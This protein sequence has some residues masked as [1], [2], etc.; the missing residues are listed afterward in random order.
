MDEQI[1]WCYPYQ[2]RCVKWTSSHK[3]ILCTLEAVS[4]WVGEEN[5]FQYSP[6]GSKCKYKYE[7]WRNT[8]ST[9]ISRGQISMQQALISV[10]CVL[11]PG[12]S[13]PL[14][15]MVGCQNTFAATP[16]PL[17]FYY[18][19][20]LYSCHELTG[21]FIFAGC[22][23]K[24]KHSGSGKALITRNPSFDIFCQS[25][26]SIHLHLYVFEGVESRTSY[27]FVHFWS[28]LISI[29][30]VLHL[31]ISSARGARQGFHNH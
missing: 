9:C 13:H 17:A 16:V 11:I 26:I 19:Q 15:G 30:L 5:S 27:S 12:S 18:L 31:F 2:P 8:V 4:Q 1:Q 10:G 23:W 24:V 14:L 21:S 25:F 22:D 6:A 20:F 28:A 7:C 29:C 3:S